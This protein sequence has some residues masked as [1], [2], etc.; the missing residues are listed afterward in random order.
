MAEEEP[1]EVSPLPEDEETLRL[2]IR[3]AIQRAGAEASRLEVLLLALGLSKRARQGLV[4]SGSQP[5]EG[6]WSVVESPRASVDAPTAAVLG[7]SPPPPP[8]TTGSG[9]TA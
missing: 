4:E 6:A 5:A 7:S 1:P 2:E 9:S 8:V 3:A